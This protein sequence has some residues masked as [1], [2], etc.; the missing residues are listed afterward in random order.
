[1]ALLQHSLQIPSKVSIIPRNL[2][3]IID[4]FS[5]S[6]KRI[7]IS[8]G[9]TLSTRPPPL[10]IPPPFCMSPLL[11]RVGVWER[12]TSFVV[13][14]GVGYSSLSCFFHLSVIF[15]VWHHHQ[16]P[17][18]YLVYIINE[19][20][21]FHGGRDLECVLKDP[22]HKCKNRNIPFDGSPKYLWR[23]II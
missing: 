1:M 17:L 3:F 4:R 10:H 21:R 22:L 11:V 2:V 12:T 8:S 16:H 14:P 20:G 7:I 23:F 5:A 13:F 9:K 15:D 18:T 19:S 6:Y